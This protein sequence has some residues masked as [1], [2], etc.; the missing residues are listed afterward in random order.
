MKIQDNH[1]YNKAKIKY[2]VIQSCRLENKKEY[3][4][5]A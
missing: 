1:R 5:L 3:K 2:V 4:Q